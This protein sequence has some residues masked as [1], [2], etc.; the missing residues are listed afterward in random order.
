MGR[1]RWRSSSDAR[2]GQGLHV[3]GAS[4]GECE[5]EGVS[6]KCVPALQEGS[7]SQKRKCHTAQWVGN[8]PP[9]EVKEMIGA[10]KYQQLPERCGSSPT[11]RSSMNATLRQ[12]GRR[13]SIPSMGTSWPTTCLPSA[14][15]LIPDQKRG[16]GGAPWEWECVGV[17]CGR[18]PIYHGD[19]EGISHRGEK[20][21]RKGGKPGQMPSLLRTGC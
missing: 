12:T 13:G 6:P 3:T 20:E 14:P 21:K 8:F 10:R 1:A 11:E 4:K 2:E 7:S 19:P 17:Q 9:L 18:K 5:S 15:A 16:W